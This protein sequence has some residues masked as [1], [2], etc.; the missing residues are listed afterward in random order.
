VLEHGDV[1]VQVEHEEMA[2]TNLPDSNYH[3]LRIVNLV[4]PIHHLGLVDLLLCRRIVR[5]YVCSDDG[6][7]VGQPKTKVLNRDFRFASFLPVTGEH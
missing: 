3:Q 4:C 5:T 7:G 6:S 1:I 2:G